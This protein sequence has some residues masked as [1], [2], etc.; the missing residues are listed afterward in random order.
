MENPFSCQKGSTIV[1]NSVFTED[2]MCNRSK[3]EAKNFYTTLKYSKNFHSLK[4]C[5]KVI[6]ILLKSAQKG[7]PGPQ[8]QYFEVPRIEK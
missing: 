2:F 8:N 3:K 1:K 6:V 4:T 5:A 7:S